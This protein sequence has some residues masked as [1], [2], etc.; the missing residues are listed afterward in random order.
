[1]LR[2]ELVSDVLDQTGLAQS[3]SSKL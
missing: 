3:L 2:L 1:L